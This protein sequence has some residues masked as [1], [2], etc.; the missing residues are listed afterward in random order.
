MNSTG[1]GVNGTGWRGR[2]RDGN[3]VSMVLTCEILNA[4]KNLCYR[5]H[6]FLLHCKDL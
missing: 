2:E 1:S 4:I 5:K 3:D 6:S